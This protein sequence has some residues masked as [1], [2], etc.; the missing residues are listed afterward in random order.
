M[1]KAYGVIH[2][3]IIKLAISTFQLLKESDVYV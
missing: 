2:E 3:V 1:S